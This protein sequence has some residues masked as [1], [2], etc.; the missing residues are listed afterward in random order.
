MKIEPLDKSG[1]PEIVSLS[2][3]SIAQITTDSGFVYRIQV[4][5]LPHLMGCVYLI[6]LD[7][8]CWALID[9]GCGDDDCNADIE[10]GL[11]IVRSDFEP[12][13]R[14][15]KI[16]YIF[17]T[18]AHIDHFGGA[19]EW[20]KRT[21]AEVWIHAFE[22]RVVEQ[23]DDCAHVE[24]RRYVAWL[25]ES[26][27]SQENVERVLKGFGFRPGR[28][29]NLPVDRKFYGGETFHSLR[30]F[31]LPGHSSGHTAFLF[32]NVIFS[33]DL[34]LSKTLTQVWPTRMT[35]QTGLLNY[36][37]S[38]K[39]LER[40]ALN[41]KLRRGKGIL[42]LPAH[43]DPIYDI[44]ARVEIALRGMERRN[45]RI[46]KILRETEKPLCLEELTRRMYLTGNSDRTFFALSDV[47]CRV[48][49]LLQLGLLKFANPER[50][51]SEEP[52]LRYQKLLANTES[53]KNTIEQV[54]RMYLACYDSD[55]I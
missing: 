29:K 21:N 54:V 51:S 11:N 19:F 50:L 46:L 25:L 28:A 39:N 15:D 6:K 12:E 8:D 22:S 35:P 14:F 1:L 7:P 42:A 23:Y 32:G 48:E 36:V 44:P 41:F 49:F 10:Y 30:F 5:A 53:T 52:V 27:V 31:Y 16:R 3:D 24:N 55:A 33:G 13:F 20:K 43:E 45:Q 17:L 9:S 37:Y 40:I 2:N 47:G 18:H 34:L 26:G 4:R 38:L